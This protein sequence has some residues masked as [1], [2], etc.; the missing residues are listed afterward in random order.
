MRETTISDSM[1]G[2]P[3]VRATLAVR[4]GKVLDEL[5]RNRLRLWPQRPPGAVRTAK[6]PGTWLRGRPGEASPV[7]QPFLKLPGSATYRTLPDGL[8]LHFS[9]DPAER[10]ADILCIE[11]CGS[12]SN[13]QDKRARFAPSTTSLLVVCPLGWLLDPVE[14]HDPT[15]RW[16][17]I[18]L[19]RAE[20][21]EALVLPVRD[22]RVLY[23][24]KPR[25][26]EGFARHQMPQPHEYFCPMEALT[27][28]RGHE[29]PE[30]TALI[31]RASATI[32]FMTPM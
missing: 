22:L 28:E 31:G 3:R 2:G 1:A 29:D 25:H 24:L 23:G 19:L 21:R 6:Q 15:P 4:T 27:A 17:L 5:V 13:L 26:Y 8:W 7:A 30:L 9:P 16:R 18:R 12:V 14:A 10:Y 11:A 20:P 32:N